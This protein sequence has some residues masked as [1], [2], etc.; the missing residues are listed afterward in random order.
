MS[1]PQRETV[2]RILPM[3]LFVT[4]R[5]SAACL[6]AAVFASSPEGSESLLGRGAELRTRRDR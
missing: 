1:G 4:A 2:C 5:V 3:A 6:R